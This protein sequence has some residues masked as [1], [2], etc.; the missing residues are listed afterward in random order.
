MQ[1]I[2]DGAER[3]RL[4]AILDFWHK[5][6]FFIP[7]DL[8]SRIVSGEGRSVFW[9][10][11]K[12]LGDDGAAL[13]RPAIPEEKQITGFTLFL[14]V[15][16]KSE[17]ADIRRH[18][19][20]VTADIAEYDDAERSDLD[21]D[22]CFASLQLSP[23]GQPMFETFSV[24][25][26][27]WALG[28][29]RK[30]GLSSLSH[31]A[32]ADSKRQLSELLQN[33]RAQRHLRSS[34]SED[35]ADQP[36]DAAEIL[37]LH[38]LLCDWAGFAS[39]QEK[40]IAAVEI[41]YRD[42][43]EKPELISLPPPPD[44]NAL[45]ADDEEDES[46]SVED[47][48]GILNS[49]FIEDIERA[50]IRVTHGDIP[51]PL[52]QYLTPLAH[53][54]RIDLYSE[55]GRRAIVRALHPGKLNRGRWLSEPHH[56]MS[57]MQQFAINSAI[58][59]LSETGLFSVNGPPGTGKTTLLRDMFA[60]NIVRRARILASLKTA[61]D[62]FDGAP[63][64]VIF[65]D[66]STASI[67]ALIPAL[68]G[69]EM[70][71]AS[72]NNAAVE[73]ISRDL[74]KRSSVA[75]TSSFQYLQT[76]AHKIAC[77]KDNGAVV[78]LSDG[79]R[80]WGLIACALGNARNRRAFKERFAF[81]EIAERPKPAWSG[82]YKP[83]SIW[84]WLKGY[85]GPNFAEASAAFQAADKM[86]RD[87]I[88]EYAR[89]ADLH[90]EI[91][92]ISQD[93]FCRE[94]LEKVRAAASELRHAQDRCDMVAAEML[95]I[96]EG[97]SQLKEEEQ[98]LDRSAPAW[99][100]K[101]LPANP[102]RQHRQNVIANAR[103][104]LELRKALAEC[105]RHIAKTHGPALKRALRG[106]Q[107]AE[108]TL[109]L[110]REIWSRKRE[111]YDRLG[112]ILD[113]PILPGRL[114]DLETDQFQID[115]L[116]HRD[117]LAGLRSALLE[118]AL[119]LHEAWLADVGKKGGGFGGNIVAIN[120]LLSN[121]GP[122]EGEHIGL[123]WQSL[124][125]IVPI[126]STTFASFARQFRGLDTGSI[127]WVFID[128][129]GQAV[130]QAAVGAL[131]RARRVMVIG[132]PQQIEPVF[133][134]P[135]ALITAISALSPHTAAGQYSPNRASVQMLADAANRYGT[136]VSGEEADGLWIGSPLRVH[137]RCID[138]MFA[139][140]NRIAYQNKMV[141]GLEE[142]RPAGDAPP[143][144]GDSA[145]IDVKGRVSGKQAV[146]EQTDFIVDVLTAT[147]RRDGALPDLY[148]ISPFKEIKN[149]LRQALTHAT[150]INP[151][152]N[153]RASP[154]KLSRWLKERIGTVHTFQGKEEDIV[155]MV[156]GAD[157]D[158]SGAA[159]W[160]ASKPNLLNV[161][162]TRAKR[163]FYI[164]GDRSLWEG[165]PYFRETA[166]ALDTLQAAEFLGRI[167]L[168]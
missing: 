154:P 92:L 90:D 85:K 53:E 119:T 102:A 45:D 18:F 25:T 15:F 127:G 9:L 97:L 4:L 146:A 69:F 11:A 143:F 98:L 14:G 135:S 13:S 111:E 149:S 10:H 20:S 141:F 101:V 112:K 91:S 31:E 114:A 54:K 118:A 164:V 89:Y 163:R 105:E 49:F 7:Y 86:V 99:W 72:S 19:D 120:R 115:G 64:R 132:D 152:G 160:A 63:R 84:E 136:A 47:D 166:S 82:A 6:E 121:N 123:I 94:A 148:I 21:G 68:A 150:W 1:T 130:P 134:L 62:A 103:R 66:R 142:R 137:R 12:T 71:V 147:Y 109:G 30:S 2:A 108:Q 51:A 153:M 104:Q 26:L 43:V 131:L 39:K 29:V 106:Y 113:H 138:P 27:P 42:R 76:I 125:M 48:I 79:D 95:R 22:T 124:F 167:E 38:E 93:A 80:P 116:W 128:E 156:L 56:A 32:F 8:S 35:T 65:S 158:H 52:R 57:L 107:R 133:T 140:A 87:K 162:L 88:G 110:Q 144:Y 44:S 126:V 75:R 60:D 78:K 50:M 46:A 73:N 33:F 155:F 139:L 165:L 24:S 5:I 70:V 55:D 61:R 3:E 34:S 100:E 122:A 168:D 67:S 151:N 59:D 145:W 40:P 28:R 83:E 161:A 58:D 17:I 117:E 74:P 159:S 37:T 77:Q 96:R 157:A 23:L 129:A 16:N 36:I 41:R 81:M